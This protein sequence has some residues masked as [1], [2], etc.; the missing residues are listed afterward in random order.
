MIG[1]A[2]GET[3]KSIKN[4]RGKAARSGATKVTPPFAIMLYKKQVLYE[5][6]KEKAQRAEAFC[7]LGAFV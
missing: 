7:L 5:N 2:G 3:N 1:V 4:L 6:E